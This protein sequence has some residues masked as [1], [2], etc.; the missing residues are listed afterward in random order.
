MTIRPAKAC[1]AVPICAI[2][3]EVIAHTAATFTSQLKTP[4]GIA[5][6][7]A[8]RGPAFQV[9]E[10]GGTVIGFA[11][12]FQFRGGPGY[13]HTMEHSIQLAP[14]ARG[15]GAGRAL[16]AA[17]EEVARQQGVHSLWAG[18]SGENPGGVIF[19]ARLGYTE[20]ARLP[21]VGRKF[22]RWMDLV[23]LQKIL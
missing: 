19:H 4:D 20:V 10:T 14:Q 15:R 13:R 8:A 3:N 11:T 23:L 12:Y 18:V 7:I 21:Q 16:L 1:D 9:A 6:D 17:L 5:T 2:W 22:D